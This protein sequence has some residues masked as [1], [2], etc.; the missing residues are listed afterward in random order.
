MKEKAK[1]RG[2]REERIAIPGDWQAAVGTA[3]KKKRP[4][5]GWPKPEKKGK[6]K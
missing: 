2:P 3:L 6:G 4:P 5:G 1:K